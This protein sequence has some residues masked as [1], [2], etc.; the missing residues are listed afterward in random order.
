M[1]ITG[2][3]TETVVDQYLFAVTAFALVIESYPAV[4]RGINGV[5][6][7]S[8]QV[9][10]LVAGD[11]SGDRMAPGTECTD[12]SAQVAF[13]DRPDGGNRFGHHLLVFAEFLQL[14]ERFG[15]EVQQSAHSVQL[16]PG[17]NHQGRVEVVVQVFVF[18]VRVGG[19]DS[20]HIQRIGAEQRTV[21]AVVAVADLL[22]PGRSGAQF[23]VQH[24]VFD[25]QFVVV[26]TD[27][28]HFG[29]VE[30]ERKKHVY[31]R[32]EDESDQHFSQSPVEF[33]PKRDGDDLVSE[34]LRVE[35]I[36]FFCHRIILCALGTTKLDE[37][38]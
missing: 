26:T 20:L 27:A 36:A 3:V 15:L 5:S 28:V 35:F 33:D 32:S 17:R 37:F 6:D 19:I 30:K 14:V 23:V 24:V 4:A 7:P 31:D 21:D 10:S 18:A 2:F 38:M 34:G 8:A 11:T 13:V 16:F 29:R 9:D 1:R 25:Q 12:V 22:Q